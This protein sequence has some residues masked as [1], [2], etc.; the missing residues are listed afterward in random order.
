MNWVS[1]RIYLIL[2]GW[3]EYEKKVHQNCTLFW[4]H[5]PRVPEVLTED[6]QTINEVNILGGKKYLTYNH[7]PK[8][9]Y[10]TVKD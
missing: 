2:V 5:R 9:S 4:G 1:P 3:E 7:F 8:T 10:L 6:N